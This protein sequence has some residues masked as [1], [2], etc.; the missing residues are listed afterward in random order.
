MRASKLEQASKAQSERRKRSFFIAT[1]VF[2]SCLLVIF[3]FQY[4]SKTQEKLPDQY[5]SSIEPKPD[6]QPA[7]SAVMNDSSARRE[8][9]KSLLREIEGGMEKTLD[10][11]DLP[12]WN[13]DVSSNLTRLKQ[14]ALAQYR[15][16]NY[17]RAIDIINEWQ[18]RARKALVDWEIAFREEFSKANMYFKA[19][20]V[21]QAQ[22]SIQKAVKLKPGDAGVISL[23]NRIRQLPKLKRLIEKAQIAKAE[24][25]IRKRYELLK[26]VKAVDPLWH[27]FDTELDSLRKKIREQTYS[28]AIARGLKAVA[29]G[30]TKMAR[31]ALSQAKNIHP[32]REETQLLARKISTYSREYQHKEFMKKSDTAENDDDWPLALYTYTEAL[33]KFPDDSYFID[34]KRHAEKIVTLHKSLDDYV[35]RHHRLS[36]LRIAKLAEKAVE[37][38]RIYSAD[39]PTLNKKRTDLEKLLA[40]YNQPVELRIKSDGKTHIVVRRIGNIGKVKNKTISLRPGKYTLEGKRQGYK[41]VLTTIELKLNQSS[42]RVDIVCNE[43]I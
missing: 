1:G 24:N 35:N 6:N 43:P 22:L 3:F 23:Q 2:T 19:L 39:S 40:D 16:G 7:Q 12:A 21:E 14:D 25:N 11:A 13:P 10:E 34:G 4:V 36:S 9:F 30:N 32:V 31:A 8:A 17:Q 33:K 15:Q 41:T 42:T 20:S 37:Q 18:T 38:S 28:A 27:E 26:Q 29:D 5:S